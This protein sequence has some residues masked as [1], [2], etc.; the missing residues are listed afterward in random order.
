[1]KL[2]NSPPVL[3]SP[4][5]SFQ[6]LAAPAAEPRRRRLLFIGEE[7]YEEP[8]VRQLALLGF[9]GQFVAQVEIGFARQILWQRPKL[10]L[11]CQNG[12]A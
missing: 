9:A 11:L 5:Q 12:D 6:S 7:S 2:R 8:D 1:M 4:R 3:S 10:A